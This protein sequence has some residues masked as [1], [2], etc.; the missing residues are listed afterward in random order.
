[1]SNMV[2]RGDF[3]V[4][5]EHNGEVTEFFISTMNFDLDECHR[6]GNRKSAPGC[7]GFRIPTGHFYEQGCNYWVNRKATDEERT[8]F[9]NWMKEHRYKLH[10]NTLNIQIVF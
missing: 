1:M 9:L 2:K 6:S 4:F 8:L 3:L 7:K 5:Q 10:R